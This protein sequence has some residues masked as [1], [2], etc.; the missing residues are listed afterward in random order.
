[1][2]AR[3]DAEKIGPNVAITENERAAFERLDSLGMDIQFKLVPDSKGF[4]WKDIKN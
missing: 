4:T 2:S 1:M 3:E